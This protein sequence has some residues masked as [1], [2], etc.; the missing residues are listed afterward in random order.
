MDSRI[1]ILG[2]GAADEPDFSLIDPRLKGVVRYADP[3]AWTMA[4]AAALALGEH[5]TQFLAAQQRAG[6][7]AVS[8]DGPLETMGTVATAAAGGF[9]SPLRYPAANPGSLAGVT[10]ILF[11]CM[12]PTMNL[13]LTPQRGAPVGLL[14]AEGWLLRGAA[15]WMLVTTCRRLPS[16]QHAARCLLLG[17]AETAGVSVAANVPPSHWLSMT[18]V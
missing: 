11:G 4:T 13:I 18:D 6:V 5:R 15:A 10:C 8:D 14:L 9:S 12:G 3:A 17:G 1:R 7:I 16:G 2:Q